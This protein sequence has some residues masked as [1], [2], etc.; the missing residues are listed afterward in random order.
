MYWLLSSLVS[1]GAPVD[2]IAAVVNSEVITLSEVYDL[3]TEFIIKEVLSVQARRDAELKVLDS[4]INRKL[5]SQEMQNLG[6][7]VT[8]EEL[9]KSI[10]DVAR[11][12]KLDIDTLKQEV[13]KSGLSWFAVRLSIILDRQASSEVRSESR[14]GLQPI[15]FLVFSGLTIP[16]RR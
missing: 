5:I 7:D 12:N 1:W 9:Q 6:L 14:G 8:E 16:N 10:A 15:V 13:L 4:L 11:A 3:G 2:R